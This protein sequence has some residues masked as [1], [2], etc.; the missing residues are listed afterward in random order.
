[1][2]IDF[3]SGVDL[4]LADNNFVRQYNVFVGLTPGFKLDMGRHWL[5]ATQGKVYL[6]NTYNNSL[7]RAY[8]NMLVLSKE[9]KAGPVC[10]KGSMGLFSNSRYGFDV[11]AFLPLTEWL[12]FEARAG[13]T[14][15]LSMATGWAMSPI[16]SIAGSTINF[17]G[18]FT[19]TIGGDIYIPRW[20]TQ[21]R[22]V[23]GKYVYTDWGFEAEA[24]RHFDHATVGL[25]VKWNNIA[26]KLNR[27]GVTLAQSL[28]KGLDG[29]FRVAV[30]IPPY[31]RV[32]RVVNFRPA[33]NFSTSYLIRG[34]NQYLNANQQYKTDPEENIRQPWFSRELLQWGSNTME[35]DFRYQ[36]GDDGYGGDAEPGG[37]DC[38]EHQQKEERE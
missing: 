11:K 15:L 22:G 35:P 30:M 17:T 16:V 6:V 36:L 20:N 2:Q 1:M 18:R 8:L 12:A 32:R 5:L 28:T 38:A 27:E 9:M 19:G 26:G 4:A 14:G 13:Y 25:Y 34:M 29:G 23:V 21:L 31:R 33:S 37:E 10:V 7:R 3:F 24:M